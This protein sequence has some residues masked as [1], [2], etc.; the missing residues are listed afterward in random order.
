VVHVAQRTDLYTRTALLISNLLF[1]ATVFFFFVFVLFDNVFVISGFKYK[2]IRCWIRRLAQTFG[3]LSRWN[4][5]F[6]EIRYY[7]GTAE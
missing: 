7:K 5:Y 2:N 4:N 1:L 6:D 3:P